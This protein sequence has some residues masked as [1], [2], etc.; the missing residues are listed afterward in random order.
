VD[1]SLANE[2]SIVT[3]PSMSVPRLLS[4]SHATPNNLLFALKIP[5]KCEVKNDY[6]CLHPGIRADKAPESF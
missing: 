5:I 1:I 4:L 6:R 3:F 2:V